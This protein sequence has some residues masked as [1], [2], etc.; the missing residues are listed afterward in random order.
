[1]DKKQFLDDIIRIHS[2]SVATIDSDN[3]PAIR[4]IDMMYLENDC[5]YF[6]IARGKYFYK[7][8]TT[9]NYI[10]L[11][12]QKYNKSYVLKGYVQQVDRKY[13]DIL[14]N[15]NKYMYGTYP[16]NTRDVLEVFRIYKWS[17]EY[18]DLTSKPITRLSFSHNIE[19]ATKGTFY[20]NDKCISCKKCIT[21]CPQRCIDYSTGKAYIKNKHC[22]R[23]G[24][25]KEVCQ[26]NAIEQTL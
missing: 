21:V 19:E 2:V 20:V 10:A 24:A 8:I 1:M 13:L 17:G 15:H 7:A 6:L 23:C 12:C 22:L 16:G 25:C 4:I 9:N 11:S 5:L 3:K 14:F 26:A 18:F